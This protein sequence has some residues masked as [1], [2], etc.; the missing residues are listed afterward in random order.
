MNSL[1]H[2]F[3]YRRKIKKKQWRD[4]RNQRQLVANRSE[5]DNSTA[6]RIMNISLNLIS[7][8]SLGLLLWTWD[9]TIGFDWFEFLEIP[10]KIPKFKEFN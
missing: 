7:L 8:C 2:G 9:A 6:T 4:I 10:M 5:S 3:Y 1:C